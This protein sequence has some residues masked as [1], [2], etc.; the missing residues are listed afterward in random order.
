MKRVKAQ[1]WET[2][3]LLFLIKYVLSVFLCVLRVLCG[4]S[5]CRVGERQEVG[6]WESGRAF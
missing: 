3:N 4:E 2:D 6:A 1:G 5:R